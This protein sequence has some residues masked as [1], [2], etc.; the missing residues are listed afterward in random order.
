MLTESMVKEE[1]TQDSENRFIEELRSEL[2]LNDAEEAVLRALNIRRP[3]E[4]VSLTHN[5]PSLATEGIDLAKLSNAGW[6]RS[7]GGFKAM[8]QKI[9]ARAN[10]TAAMEIGL[11]AAYPAGA[12]APPGSKVPMPMARQRKRAKA[13]AGATRGASVSGTIDVRAPKWAVKDQGKRGT[14][15]AFATVACREHLQHQSRGKLTILSE[16]YLYWA[17]KKKTGDP[18]PAIDGTLLRFA[19]DAIEQIG[20]CA[21][22]L[23][24]YDKRKRAGDITHESPRRP[25][26][27]A[28]ADA[29]AWK[30]AVGSYAGGSSAGSGNAAALLNALTSTGR[31]VAISLPVFTDP[32]VGVD[33]W[34][35]PIGVLY[36]RVIDPP[37]TS[38]AFGLGHAVCVC[39][40][41][42]DAAESNGGYFIVRNSWGSRWG[43]AAPTPGYHAFERGYGEVS[44]TYVE[45][46]LWEMLVF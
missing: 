21:G 35:T 5:F 36:G 28:H 42:P 7:A 1:F 37:P 39:G 34:N 19:K 31:P 46:Y 3:E 43:I 12:P 17:T 24:L 26:R 44:A 15:V 41:V 38:L 27:A 25:S 32:T 18:F 29:S 33:N 16:Q 22:S 40:F 8:S 6:A 4:L 11:G 20:T 30:Q 14:C 23:W 10:R 13:A 45:K 2:Q 9:A